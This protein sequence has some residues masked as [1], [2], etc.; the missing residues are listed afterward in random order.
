MGQVRH[1]RARRKTKALVIRKE[2]VA[3]GIFALLVVFGPLTFGAVDRLTQVGLLVLLTIGVALQ[4][5][6]VARPTPRANALIV[7]TVAIL[8]LKE[9]APSTWFGSTEWHRTLSQNF[10]VVFPWTHN[11]EPARALD[12]LL[13]GVVAFVWFFWVRTLALNREHRPILV[14][15]MFASTAITAAVSFATRD[16]DPYAIFGLRYTPG[17]VGFG[18]FPNRNHSACFL[19][20]GLV[21][22]AGCVAWAGVRRKFPIMAGGIV[23]IGLV[24]AAMLATQ[25][26][27]GVVVSAVG[28]AVF[29]ALALIKFRTQRA[30]GIA[31]G[32][33]LMLASIALAFGAQVIARFSSKEAG[34]VSTLLRVRIW[35]DTFRMWKDAPIFG[36]G[37][38]SFPQLFP[39]YQQVDTGSMIVMHPES[40]WLQWLVELGALPVLGGLVALVIF[41]IP[42]VRE[43]FAANRTIFLRAGAFGA[44]AILFVHSLFDVPAHRWG[45]AGFALAALAVACAPTERGRFL[46]PNGRAALVPAAIAAFWALSILWEVPAWAPSSLNRL[47]TRDYMT[48]YVTTA[49]LQRAVGYFPLNP[50]L[51]QAIGMHELGSSVGARSQ[52]WQQHFRIAMRLAP[53]AWEAARD[54]ARACANAS[55]GIAL[56][57]WQVA[58]EGAGPRA[59]EV[60]G[61]AMNETARLPGATEAWFQY[62]ESHPALLL[63]FS[64]FAPESMGRVAFD[65]WWKQR[66]AMA[67]DLSDGEIEGFY[68][69]V[70]HWG[71]PA[72]LALFQQYHPE[73]KAR[74]FKKWV[75]VLHDWK[76]DKEAWQL[77]AN[78]VPEPDFTYIPPQSDLEKLKVGWELNKHQFPNARDYAAVLTMKAKLDPAHEVDS[79]DLAREVIATV[80]DFGEA[81]DWFVRKGAHLLAARGDFEEAVRLYLRIPRP[82]VPILKSTGP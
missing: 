57:Y 43:L 33:S 29:F 48:P 70:V 12:G 73:L 78:Q 19:A 79:L 7:A 17:W 22:G 39:I 67:G 6:V 21:L 54:Q 5:P 42:R 11:P 58:I 82:Q 65:H 53:G 31:L 75:S 35:E 77:I 15:S 47:L 55:P 45:T 36:H 56:H 50:M 34:E 2:H 13:A 80:A 38:Q 74:D 40:S 1:Y 27:G 64:N 51:H 41:V 66:G 37:L 62:A 26:R 18:P 63:A 20:M 14:W 59:S 4:P 10:G 61:M 23:L 68:N 52:D 25:S 46:L 30:L 8:L 28:L 76:K 9:F 81:P 16:L 49:E 60:F 3:L 32:G 24:L 71:D 44:A 72:Q 69:F